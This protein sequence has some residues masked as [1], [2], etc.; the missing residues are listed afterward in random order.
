[1]CKLR[2]LLSDWGWVKLSLRVHL[3]RESKM[4]VG[5]STDSTESVAAIL[6]FDAEKTL[7][8]SFDETIIKKG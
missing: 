8:R 3:H 7:G 6:D 5:Q 2:L 1:M 4:A